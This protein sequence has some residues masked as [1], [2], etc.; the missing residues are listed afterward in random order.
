MTASQ[1]LCSR[2]NTTMPPWATQ[3][4]RHIA[5][6]SSN[7][8]NFPLPEKST[9]STHSL[10]YSPPTYSTPRIPNPRLQSLCSVL[11]GRAGL[12]IQI[13]K[14]QSPI[15]QEIFQPSDRA[16]AQAQAQTEAEQQARKSRSPSGRIFTS[17]P[18][19]PW[20]AWKFTL[21]SPKRRTRNSRATGPNTQ[22][23]LHTAATANRRPQP[24]PPKPSSQA[25]PLNSSTA[26]ETHTCALCS[27]AFATRRHWHVHVTD[28]HC[29]PSGTQCPFCNKTYKSVATMS[30]HV[31][32]MHASV[33]VRKNRGR[34]REVSRG[35]K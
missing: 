14:Y 28:W 7:P 18:V 10:L 35:S 32:H 31:R 12:R 3:D 25:L 13:P 30:Q 29:K 24:S 34:K 15:P 20:A 26:P 9:G 21:Q 22:R 16:Q 23:Q 5:N 8:P 11:A 2:C 6:T 17:T 1:P 4:T 27:L 19:D 33:R